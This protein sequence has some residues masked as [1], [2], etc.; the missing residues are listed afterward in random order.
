MLSDGCTSLWFQSNHLFMLHLLPAVC[1]RSRN[2]CVISCSH[3]ARASAVTFR[4]AT[5]A[6]AAAAAVIQATLTYESSSI[7]GHP[8]PAAAS[9]PTAPAQRSAAQ[10]DL[11]HS[12]LCVGTARQRTSDDGQLRK[13]HASTTAESVGLF[14]RGGDA[15]RE[16][17]HCGCAL[18]AD[19]A[20]PS[21]SSNWLCTAPHAASAAS[22]C[23][24]C[25]AFIKQR[26]S[27]LC[28][29]VIPHAGRV[30]R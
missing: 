18:A 28:E 10:R 11:Q 27:L 4:T 19:G 13:Q 20:R 25:A 5:P 1:L 22:A 8:P 2:I 30:E 24:S 6:A 26:S 7:W 15:P 3:L 23:I 17:P 14:P 16:V 12:S 29:Y 21:V 9:P